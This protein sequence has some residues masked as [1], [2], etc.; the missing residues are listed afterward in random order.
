MANRVHAPAEGCKGKAVALHTGTDATGHHNRLPLHMPAHG[1]IL[2]FQVTHAVQQSQQQD[3]L[4]TSLHC[5]SIINRLGQQERHI[6]V[7]MVT[8][9]TIQGNQTQPNP[10]QRQQ[11]Y[12]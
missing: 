5:V 12:W 4:H 8:C 6:N 2:P 3:L 10:I 11:L 9:S 7:N 1:C